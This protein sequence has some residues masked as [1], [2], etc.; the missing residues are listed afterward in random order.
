MD[1]G[2][3]TVR[4]HTPRVPLGFAASAKQ[5]PFHDCINAA[6]FHLWQRSPPRSTRSKVRFDKNI[7]KTSSNYAGSCDHG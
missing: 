4:S 1:A 2:A 7:V 3:E 5:I 6:S